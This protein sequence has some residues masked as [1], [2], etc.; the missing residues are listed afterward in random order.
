MWHYGARRVFLAEQT[1]IGAF[2]TFTATFMP[3]DFEHL[4][5][6]MIFLWAFGRRVE[7]ACGPWR[8]LLFYLFTGMVAIM[9]WY[10]VITDQDQ[11]GIG[12]SG[13]ISGVMGAYIV[14]FPGARVGCLWLGGAILRAIGVGLL[15]LLGI[16]RFKFRWLAY[17]PAVIVLVFYMGFD[18]QQTFRSVKTR[19]MTSGVNYIAHAAGFLSAVTVLLFV[20]KDLLVRYF[21]RRHI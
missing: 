14:L 4:I 8:F 3:A 20:R 19:E 21:S 5:G 12:A 11:P 7:D 17:L 18:I 2:S 16:G 9:G 15:R 1:G 6:N 13:A 10:F